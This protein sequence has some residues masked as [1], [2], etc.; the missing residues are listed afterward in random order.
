MG[1]S[2]RDRPMHSSALTLTTRGGRARP[3][4][5]WHESPVLVAPGRGA[6]AVDFLC[7]GRAHL[8]LSGN[9][10]RVA[11]PVDGVGVAEA[12]APERARFG[13]LDSEQQLPPSGFVGADGARARDDERLL[14]LPT[15]GWVAGPPLT[16]D[17][18]FGPDELVAEDLHPLRADELH[19]VEGCRLVAADHQ[20]LQTVGE[21]VAGGH[22]DGVPVHR[23]AA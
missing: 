11:D 15:L 16:V 17:L 5:P 12:V 20:A 7:G 18:A 22:G 2:F 19:G 8:E 9:R 21:G 13:D 4:G 10:L 1:A 6:G 14:Q 3:V 23:V